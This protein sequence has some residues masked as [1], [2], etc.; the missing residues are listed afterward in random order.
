VNVRAI[1][2]VGMIVRILRPKKWA[3]Q[4]EFAFPAAQAAAQPRANMGRDAVQNNVANQRESCP[5]AA[6]NLS[7]STPQS[8]PEVAGI[9]HQKW[10]PNSYR[11]NADGKEKEESG[12][13]AAAGLISTAQEQNE[14]AAISEISP[15]EV[16]GLRAALRS[17]AGPLSTR[18]M[19]VDE[20]QD[21]KAVLRR[22][23]E[24]LR[25]AGLA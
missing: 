4:A 21:R 9:H 8:P 16:S 1:P 18:P 11:S 7:K 23:A 3:R 12:A 17:I 5:N 25:K 10:W 6:D 19:T 13:A 24:Q 20:F 15:A 2:H 22:Q 14:P